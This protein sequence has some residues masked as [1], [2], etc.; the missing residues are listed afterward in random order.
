MIDLDRAS[1]KRMMALDPMRY[2]LEESNLGAI[3]ANARKRSSC[4]KEC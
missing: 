1:W 2:D 4:S 3:H